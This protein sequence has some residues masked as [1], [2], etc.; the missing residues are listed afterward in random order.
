MDAEQGDLA[1]QC[2]FFQKHDDKII[3]TRMLEYRKRE[4]EHRFELL[5]QAFILF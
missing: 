3:T 5:T 4:T 1:P 2:V